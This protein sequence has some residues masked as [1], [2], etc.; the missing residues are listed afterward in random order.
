MATVKY[1]DDAQQERL[2]RLTHLREARKDIADLES[3]KNTAE[4]AKLV[5]TYRKWISFAKT[6]EQIANNDHDRQE[7]DPVTFSGRV[8]R[9]RQKQADFSLAADVLDKHS[10]TLKTLD[11]EISRIEAMFKEAKEVL[12]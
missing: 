7:I 2:R 8:I 6:E 1:T 12:D 10:E 11:A 4:W 5:R 3:L 9:A